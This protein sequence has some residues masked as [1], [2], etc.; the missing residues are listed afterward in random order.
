LSTVALLPA[1]L[2]EPHPDEE[3]VATRSATRP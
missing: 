2:F 1:A 3:N